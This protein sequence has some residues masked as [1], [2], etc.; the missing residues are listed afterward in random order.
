MFLQRLL[1]L[2][3]AEITQL[4]NTLPVQSISAT[5]L[6]RAEI[7]QLSNLECYLRNNLL[8]L[9]RAEITQLSNI[10]MVTSMKK[11]L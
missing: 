4:S 10:G 7:T 3:R 2:E 9:E 5:A 6:E 1:A 11:E 8:A